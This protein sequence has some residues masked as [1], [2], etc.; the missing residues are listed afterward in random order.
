MKIAIYGA[1]RQEPFLPDLRRLIAHLDSLGVETSIHHKLGWYLQERDIPLLSASICERLP[2]AADLVLSIGGD[3]T[4]LRTAR[5][6]GRSEVP[7][8]GVNTGHL[9]FLASCRLEEVP[10]MLGAFATGDVIIEKRMLLW[11]QTDRLPSDEWPYALNEVGLQKEDT[12]SMVN[13][14]AYINGHHLANYR[15]D[16]LIVSTPT[17][18]TAY[19][20]AAGGPVVEPTIDCM[21]ITPVAPHTM[22]LRPLVAGGDSEL[23]LTVDGRSRDFRLS[24]DSRSH[25]LPVGTKVRIKRAGFVTKLV[26]RKDSPFPRILADKLHW[27]S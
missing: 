5:W 3:G 15:A 11:V 18:S 8:L 22:T 23:E 21:V 13:I 14:K 10:L 24:L 17:G 25:V 9:G 7:I 20:L 27:G 19:N 4:F 6:V 26:R 2:E 12:A 16:G 1:R